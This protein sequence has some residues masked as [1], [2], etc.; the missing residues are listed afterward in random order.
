[1]WNSLIALMGLLP[2]AALA[3]PLTVTDHTLEVELDRSGRGSVVQTWSVR[4]DDVAQCQAGVIGPP[5]LD[6]AESDGARMLSGLFLVPAEVASGQDFTLSSRRS[7]DRNGDAGL[8]SL[9][10]GVP[11]TS[12]RVTLTS[13]MRSPVDVWADPGASLE[14]SNTSR[15]QTTTAEWNFAEDG[16]LL[17]STWPDW[18]AVGGDVTFQVDALLATRTELGRDLVSAALNE[19]LGIA[20]I[21]DSVRSRVRVEP[22]D[23]GSLANARPAAEAVQT[24]DGTAVERA[25]VL[26][27]VLREQGFDARFGQVRPGAASP[28]ISPIPPVPQAFPLPAVAVVSADA[29]VWIDPASDTAVPP[30]IPAAFAD[31]LGWLTGRSPQPIADHAASDIVIT[32][33]GSVSPDGQVLWDGVLTATG[34]AEETL[35]SVLSPLDPAD[36]EARFRTLLLTGRGPDARATARLS[37]FSQ[38]GEPLR[39]DLQLAEPGLF[40]AAGPGLSGAVQPVLAP[41]LVEWLPGQSTVT[42]D[43]VLALP[44]A[45]SVLGMP[46]GATERTLNAEVR[47]EVA[48]EPSRVRIQTEA[49]RSEVRVDRATVSPTRLLLL[50]PMTRPLAKRIAKT[51][52]LDDSTDALALSVQLLTQTGLDNRAAKQIDKSR[53][54]RESLVWRIAERSTARDHAA[55]DLM[56]RMAET[57]EQ[58][59]DVAEA[60]R[61]CCGNRTAWLRSAALVRTPAPDDRLE[62]ILA[63]LALQPDTQPTSLGDPDGHTAWYEPETLL[64]WADDAAAASPT[65]PEQGDPRLL[66]LQASKALMAGD[67]A[68]AESL[69]MRAM[70]TSRDPDLPLLYAQAGAAQGVNTTETLLTADEAVARAPSD[71][72]VL[73]VAA[74]VLDQVGLHSA[75]TERRRAAAH[76]LHSDD[77]LWLRISHDALAGADLDTALF[78]ARRASDLQPGTG[79]ASAWLAELAWLAG[80]TRAAGIAASRTGAGARAH[81]DLDTVLADVAPDRRAAV[82]EWRD[83]E[84]R[85]APDALAERALIRLERGDAHAAALDGLWLETVLEEDRGASIVAA[86]AASRMSGSFPYTSDSDVGAT[87]TLTLGILFGE[88]DVSSAADRL[89]DTQVARTIRSWEADPTAL[90]LAAQYLPAPEPDVQR[91]SGYVQHDVLGRLPGV[92]AWTRPGQGRAAVVTSNAEQGLPPLLSVVTVK[93]SPA[94]RR[95]QGGLIE[96]HDGLAMPVYTARMRLTDGVV[97]GIGFTPTAAEQAARDVLS[98]N[99]RL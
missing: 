15:T 67:P 62:A 49:R 18:V 29:T 31:G 40:H 20:G 35:R 77:A 64:R 70:E 34:A 23:L 85:Q 27:S 3:A 10:P 73:L 30:G 98:A 21:V 51:P 33:T 19:G 69:L 71:P 41:A 93:R 94:E 56:W 47:R 76:L 97:W 95:I 28:D 38:L 82:L 9:A 55:L 99:P 22:G 75:A 92:L 44:D 88:G 37:N 1:M 48:I 65:T 32:A 14:G 12:A 83:D 39:I 86:A 46:S 80:D 96:R 89:G 17:W 63:T 53:V 11:T 13:R 43:V 24:G 68:T 57:D 52:W 5:G 81:A 4:I 60:L 42:E 6:G 25:L 91:P 79:G 54:D 2:V 36:R 50:P 74:T 87:L 58:R 8:F 26:L 84:V 61:S 78:A 7:L 45:L 72:A 66:R 90:A 59:L 16:S